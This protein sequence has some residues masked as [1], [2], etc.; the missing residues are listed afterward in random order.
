MVEKKKTPKKWTCNIPN[1]CTPQ[2]VG[3]LEEEEVVLKR[4]FRFE[5]DFPARGNNPRT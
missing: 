2:R 1:S 3:P 5:V 4:V